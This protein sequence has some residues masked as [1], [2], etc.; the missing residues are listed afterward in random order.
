MIVDWA[1]ATFAGSRRMLD[2]GQPAYRAPSWD[3]L[4]R[5]VTAF[6]EEYAAELVA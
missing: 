5:M 2:G 6:L 1:S 3:L 4:Q